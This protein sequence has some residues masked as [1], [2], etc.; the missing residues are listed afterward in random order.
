[1]ALT[2]EIEN[3]K[4]PKMFT[5]DEDDLLGE[6]DLLVLNPIPAMAVNNQQTVAL[7]GV[8]RPFIVTELEKDYKLTWDAQLKEELELEYKEKPVLIADTVYPS[9]VSILD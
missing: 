7:T 3:I 1:M 5:L 8:L 2:G 6:E 9:R 4:N